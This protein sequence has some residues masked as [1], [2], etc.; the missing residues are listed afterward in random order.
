M[1]VRTAD[2][3][4]EI[5]R[6]YRH[7]GKTPSIDAAMSRDP[8]MP[9]TVPVPS[10]R[11][12]YPVN[13]QI[14]GPQFMPVSRYSS[15]S[16]PKEELQKEVPQNINEETPGTAKPN[17]GGIL[18]RFKQLIGS[19]STAAGSAGEAKP[20][21]V[22]E[23]QQRNLISARVASGEVGIRAQ[24]SPQITPEEIVSQT[25]LYDAF[26][27]YS[28]MDET[29]MRRIHDSLRQQG[30]R[31]WMD[32]V[33]LKPGEP[34]WKRAIQGAIDSSECIIVLLSPEAKQSEWVSKE[35]DY[36]EAMGK[37]IYPVLIRGNT[38]TSVPFGFNSSQW[39]DIR[40]EGQYETALASLV[41]SISERLNISAMLQ[42]AKSLLFQVYYPR[43]L[44]IN[45]WHSMSV[46]IFDASATTSVMA[47][48]HQRGYQPVN[49][50]IPSG[51]SGN[52]SGIVL[53]MDIPRLLG[54]QLTPHHV[55][56]G[57]YRGW[58]RLDFDLRA[59]RSGFQQAQGSITFAI[60]GQDV[61]AIPLS[62]T[63]VDSNLE[64]TG[65]M[66]IT[67]NSFD[68]I[69]GS[70]S[71]ADKHIVRRIQAAYTTMGTDYI[72]DMTT[73]RMSTLG[74]DIQSVEDKI[75]QA[76]VFQLFWSA[77]A[78]RSTAVE[79]EWRY[80]LHLIDEGVKGVDFIRPVYWEYP[81]AEIPFELQ[82]LNFVYKPE[83]T[84]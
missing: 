55:T 35:L 73:V 59:Y 74:E 57:F 76:D 40:D 69:F 81:A 41:Q 43:E 58:H 67:R 14:A 52:S 3:L 8:A 65:T 24:T 62:F 19:G 2:Q 72:T 15:I 34:S 54:L 32:K 25:V 23:Q 39:L 33:G 12:P 70:Y 49:T 16:T 83:L 47:D 78:A 45:E 79:R 29:V 44:I 48:A 1:R 21:S 6:N 53:E 71:P 75:K 50:T 64:T 28:R 27:S 38:R 46:Y 84:E 9:R 61:A 37:P 80:A 13:Q 26:I 31:I 66:G 68:S 60:R 11:P 20:E 51:N 17:V 10:S 18:G 5:L 77:A 36:A 42:K 7:K 22:N 82:H 30:L 4:E 56:L 63:I